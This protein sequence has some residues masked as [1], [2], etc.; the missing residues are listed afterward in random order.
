VSQNSGVSWTAV[1]PTG[2]WKGVA[3]STDGM[4]LAAADSTGQLQLSSDS[5]LTWAARETTRTWQAVACSADGSRLVAVATAG[6]PYVS[7]PALLY[8][9]TAGTSGQLIGGQY[10]AVALQYLGSGLFTVPDYAGVFGV[11]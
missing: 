10:A 4:R 6:R 1:G 2:A 5:G 9:T 8:T 7:A 11:L 3:S